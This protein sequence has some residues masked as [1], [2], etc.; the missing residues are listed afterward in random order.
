[1]VGVCYV[2]LRPLDNFGQIHTSQKSLA[3]GLTRFKNLFD[4]FL[5]GDPWV[6]RSHIGR[7]SYFF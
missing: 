3:L 7:Q 1:M 6:G 5:L 4:I 2:G